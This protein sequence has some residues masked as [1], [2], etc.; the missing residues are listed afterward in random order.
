[1]TRSMDQ[2]QIWSVDWVNTSSQ[3]HIQP[4]LPLSR[5]GFSLGAA[6]TA[7]FTCS[8]Q[9]FLLFPPPASL[10]SR[11]FWL[12][13][14][15]LPIP[16]FPSTPNF[17][18]HTRFPLHWSSTS[19]RS[20]KGP[21]VESVSIAIVR[22]KAPSSDRGDPIVGPKTV[23]PLPPT[24]AKLSKPDRNV[25]RIFNRNKLTEQSLRDQSDSRDI[26]RKN[27]K[28]LF[29]GVCFGKTTVVNKRLSQICILVLKW[30]QMGVS[31]IFIGAVPMGRSLLN[32]SF[33]CPVLPWLPINNQQL[34]P[35]RHVAI[36]V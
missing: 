35:W 24:P 13:S 18:H 9:N 7:A 25:S 19:A 28:V 3:Q 36:T 10:P 8:H 21:A 17:Q 5:S 14:F 6:W 2:R 4:G 33:R 30:H 1:M 31:W 27:V 32:N 20:L 23:P 22:S 26:R 12:I 11:F 16:S 34:P 29:V 15:L